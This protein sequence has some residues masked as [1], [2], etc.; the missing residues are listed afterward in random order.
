MRFHDTRDEDRITK[1]LVFQPLKA[2]TR[3]VGHQPNA[4]EVILMEVASL[5]GRTAAADDVTN[6][7][8]TD[9]NMDSL[10]TIRTDLV[11]VSNVTRDSCPLDLLSATAVRIVKVCCK[12]IVALN[13]LIQPAFRVVPITPNMEAY[14][15]PDTVSIFI[16]RI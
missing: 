15:L 5:F 2:I 1:R 11:K 9:K 7:Q 13:Y 16:V 12:N 14:T 4:P 8:A 10:R 6:D 3:R